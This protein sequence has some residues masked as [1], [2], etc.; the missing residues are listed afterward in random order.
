MLDIFPSETSEM[1]KKKTHFA[2][3]WHKRAIILPPAA[4]F[5]SAATWHVQREASNFVIFPIPGVPALMADHVALRPLPTAVS[6][7][8]PV[9]IT[10][11]ITLSCLGFWILCF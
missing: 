9:I 10:F 1:L 7:P 8:M 2:G 6:M 3:F 11:F 4:P 5:I